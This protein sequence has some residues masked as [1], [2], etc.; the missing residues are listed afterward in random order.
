MKVRNFQ[1]LYQFE[2]YVV[3]E[4]ICEEIGAQINLR[5]DERIGPRYPHCQSKLP[6]NKI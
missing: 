3:E 1:D 2:G 6:R 5:F 4:L